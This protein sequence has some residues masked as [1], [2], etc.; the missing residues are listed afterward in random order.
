ML[1]YMHIN[2]NYIFPSASYRIPVE[3]KLEFAE[4]C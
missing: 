1:I 2:N 4:R 3:L